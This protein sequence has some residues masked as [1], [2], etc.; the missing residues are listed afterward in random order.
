VPLAG[1]RSGFLAIAALAACAAHAGAPAAEISAQHVPLC[2]GLTIVTAVS[3][4][5]G[6]YESIKRVESVTRERVRIKYSSE[7]MVK[8]ELSDEPPKLVHST[9][10]RSVRLVDLASS[11]VYEQQFYDGLPEVIPGTTAIGTSAAVLQQLKTRGQSPFSIFIAFAGEPSMN[12]DD[13]FY[14]FNNK[15]ESTIARVEGQPVFVAVI[16]ND[17]PVRLPA[18][19]AKGYFQGDLTDFYFL[20]DPANPITLQ[21]RSGIG[22]LRHVEGDRIVAGSEDG[23]QDRDVLQVVK[24]SAHCD[25]DSAASGPSAVEDSLAKT[26]RALVYDIYFNFNSATLRPESDS[27]LHEIAVA[28]QRHPDWKLDVTGHTDNIGG[29][30]SN[31]ILSRQRAAAVKAALTARFQ[32]DP[33]RLATSGYGASRPQDTNATLEGR[34]RNRR[35]ELVRE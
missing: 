19:H 6:D 23:R 17:L 4:P 1:R 34:A 24:I 13:V 21:Y 33:Q 15:M 35:V 31:L 7:A 32:V 2:A 25:G 11:T 3:Q 5:E 12:P 14:V 18:I 27:S 10:Y 28:L 20:D 16:L 29:D 22:A 9:V 8:D 30:N 26:G